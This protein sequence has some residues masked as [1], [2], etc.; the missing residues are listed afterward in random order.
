MRREIFQ[1]TDQYRLQLNPTTKKVRTARDTSGEL[2]ITGPPSCNMQANLLHEGGVAKAPALSRET[3][4]IDVYTSVWRP[5]Y[6][7]SVLTGVS[8]WTMQPRH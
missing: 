5:L 2:A 6:F 1:K 7:A 3:T 8:V 4:S